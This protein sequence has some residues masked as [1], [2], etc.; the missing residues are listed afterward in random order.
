MFPEASLMC[1]LSGGSILPSI[2][3]L[4][5]VIKG[6]KSGDKLLDLSNSGLESSK[7]FQLLLNSLDLLGKSLLLVLWDGDAH[8]SVVGVDGVEKASNAIIGLLQDVLSLLQVSIGSIKVE[9][10]LDLLDLFLS[11][12]EVAGNGLTVLSISNEG[13][14][15]LIE[16]LE[17]VLG[18]LLGIFPSILDTV[19]IG[20][21]EL[22]FVRVL[23]DDL[24]LGNEICDNVSL[25][26][27]LRKGLFL[28]LNQ[29]INI[30]KTGWSNFSG[31]R[32][33]NSIKELDMGLQF[34]TIGIALPVKIHHDSG[35]LDIGDE[36]LMLLD[37][38]VQFS[39]F[40]LSLTLSTLSHQDLQ[41][42][43]QPFLNLSSLKIFTQRIECVSFSLEFRGSVDFVCHDSSNGLL[44]ILHPLGHLQMPHLVHLLDEGI[45]LLPEGHDDK[46]SNPTTM[47]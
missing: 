42:L 36:L 37:Q 5:G 16:E 35:L 47:L 39:H 23:E 14:L 25:G 31:G 27:Q 28:S 21:K 30:L 34:I 20:L 26:I 9:D 43:I 24:T 7:N 10:L 40:A 4:E 29:L 12:L 45:V 22:G 18:L 6:S 1:E 38:D 8:A 32:Q 15:G 46:F 11:N 2:K 13:I 17:S 33:H 19:D 41:N 44:H 3:S